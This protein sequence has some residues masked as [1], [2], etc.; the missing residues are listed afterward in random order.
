MTWDHRKHA[1]IGASALTPTEELN[2]VA[3]IGSNTT[4][5]LMGKAGRPGI[6][7]PQGARL[8]SIVN[9]YDGLQLGTLSVQTHDSGGSEEPDYSVE[10]KAL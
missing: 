8:L 9:D 6:A 7:I 3:R 4:N 2:D 5:V 10:G 1:A